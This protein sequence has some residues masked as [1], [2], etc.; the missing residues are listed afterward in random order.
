MCVCVCVNGRVLIVF[1]RIL[2][3]GYALYPLRRGVGVGLEK[4]RL[5]TDGRLTQFV[6]CEASLCGGLGTDAF[7]SQALIVTLLQK[8]NVFELPVND[9]FAS[10]E[11][12]P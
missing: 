5:Y 2:F 12:L 4:D 6:Y 11:T 1:L 8:I 9:S 7:T 3:L 10:E